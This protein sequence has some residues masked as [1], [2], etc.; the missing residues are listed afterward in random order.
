MP[1]AGGS[2]DGRLAWGVLSTAAI[3]A[4][5]IPGLQRSLANTVT[6]VGSRQADRAERFAKQ[7]QLSRAYGSYHE[8]LADPEIDCVYICLPNSLHGRWVTSA[9]EAGKHV[10]CE[11]PLTPTEQEARG[12][13]EL[14]ERRGLVLAEA[15]MYRHHPKARTL[16]DLVS[17]GT[18]GRVRTIRGSFNFTV[19]DPAAD[20][21]YDPALSGGSLLDVGPY[22]VSL[23]S[24]LMDE[25]PAEVSGTASY[26]ASGVDE[27]FYGTMVFRAGAVSIFDCAMN[28]PL[29]MGAS[30]LGSEAEAVVEVPWY[31]HRPPL[32]I[33]VHYPDGR[34]EQVDA[35]GDNA[36]FLETEDFA[37]VVRG[38]KEPEVPAAETLRNLRT[39]ERLR[40]SAERHSTR[41]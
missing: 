4:E 12:L 41:T 22:C 30:V 6:A 34:R 24:Y 1:P 11:K 37:A 26:A 39:L 3:A 9:L 31:A 16:R 19:A 36:Y 27:Q 21:R 14:A 32:A 13:F 35:A 28:A 2:G 17:S 15:L 38:E 25:E 33:E 5:V 10:L 40:A 29:S 23:A 20:I 8:L 7:Y 18:L